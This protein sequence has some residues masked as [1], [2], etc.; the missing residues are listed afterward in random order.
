MLL[1]AALSSRNLHC[2]RSRGVFRVIYRYLVSRNITA[3]LREHSECA[4]GQFVEKKRVVS[5]VIVQT[6]T[7]VSLT[8]DFVFFVERIAQLYTFLYQD[9]YSFVYYYDLANT[10]KIGP[11]KHYI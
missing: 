8:G 9:L 6:R 10:K 2:I 1:Y 7:F 5:R 11:G 4:D 3:V